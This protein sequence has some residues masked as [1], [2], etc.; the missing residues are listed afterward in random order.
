MTPHR[1]SGEAIR[2][3]SCW[4]ARLWADDVSDADKKAFDAWRLDH[5]DN[6][7]AWQQLNQLQTQFSALPQHSASRRILM[8]RRGLSRRRL[9]SVIVGVG[10][11]T[12]GWTLGGQQSLPPGHRYATAV[13]EIRSLT[14]NDG[15]ALVLNTDTEVYVDI[16]PQARQL[17]LTQG[18][19]MVTTEHHQTPFHFSSAQG[20][21]TPIGTRYT[22]RQL[23]DSTVV[24]VQEGQV[25]LAPRESAQAL[26][27]AAGEWADFSA[28]AVGAVQ[29]LPQ[30]DASW[31]S[32][33]LVAHQMPLTVLLDELSRYRQGILSID[34]ALA[35][36]AVTGVF[37]LN[38]IDQ[39][40]RQLEQILP[41]QV[42][43][44]TR[45]WVSV[46]PAPVA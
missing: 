29:P 34:P 27:L 41:I 25:R 23:E 20:Q 6:E 1:L 3:A 30:Y 15:T 22:V 18:E 39:V 5:P 21:V 40:L 26:V 31:V 17:T 43:F 28:T 38:Q 14:L 45:Y 32:R 19:V 46:V 2:Q 13:G 16:T 44:F 11:L 4:M 9:L 37:D 33:R 12:G 8:A 10:L 7:S 42:R 24:K 36:L 35:S